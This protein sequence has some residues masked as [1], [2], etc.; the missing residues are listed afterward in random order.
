MDLEPVKFD[1]NNNQKIIAAFITLMVVALI[2]FGIRITSRSKASTPAVSSASVEVTNPASETPKTTTP[3]ATTPS[4][5]TQTY[6]DGTY[7][8]T[9]SYTSPGGVESISVTLILKG[10][11]VVDSTVI[12][13]TKDR[14]SREYQDQFISGYKSMVVGKNIKTIKLSRVSG[15]SLTSR[16]FNNA[17]TS[18]EAQA[19]P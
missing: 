16:G 3:A 11:T 17:L 8:A 13:G 1:N 14:D 4:T 15:S 10:D 7:S 12:A 9:G 19:Q 2:V 18:I 6:K 5:T